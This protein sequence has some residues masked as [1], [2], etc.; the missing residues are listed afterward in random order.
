MQL[1]SFWRR[2]SNRGARFPGKGRELRKV[3]ERLL[4]L[5]DEDAVT[6]V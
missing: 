5:N 4:V 1:P 2:A 3:I 6:A